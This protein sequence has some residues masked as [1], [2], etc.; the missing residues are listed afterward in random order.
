MQE[1]SRDTSISTGV[2]FFNTY[3][4]ALNTIMIEDVL[5]ILGVS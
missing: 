3:N 1:H 2:L 5:K 4:K